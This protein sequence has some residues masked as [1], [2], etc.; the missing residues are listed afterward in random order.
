MLDAMEST[1]PILPPDIEAAVEAS[2]GGPVA[3]LGQHG[4]YV[5]MNADLYGGVMGANA[6]ELADSVAAIKRSLAQAAAGQTRDIDE[7]LDDL[8]ARYAS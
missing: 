1:N 4:R 5:I 8:D 7:A 3:I 6:Q 2:H